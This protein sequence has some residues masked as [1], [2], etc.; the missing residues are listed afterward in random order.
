M[1]Y[2]EF[3][4]TER[5]LVK[6]DLNGVTSEEVEAVICNPFKTDRSNSSGRPL[7]KGLSDDGRTIVCIYEMIDELRV[8][9]IT[10]YYSGPKP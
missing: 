7:A 10:A 2:Y 1:P 6:I 5:A 4:W 9:P 3:V 8:L